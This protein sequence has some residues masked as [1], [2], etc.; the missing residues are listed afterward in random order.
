MKRRNGGTGRRALADDARDAALD[1]AAAALAAIQLAKQVRADSL[2]HRGTVGASGLPPANLRL[3]M[4]DIIYGAVQLQVDFARRLF[5]FN[6]S[7]SAVLRD[8]LRDHLAEVPEAQTIDGTFEEGQPIDLHFVVKNG[9]SLSKTFEFQALGGYKK[10]IKFDPPGVTL[11]GRHQESDNRKYIR[12]T[13]D[14][15][16]VGTY[17]GHISV[18]SQGIRLELRRF[19]ITITGKK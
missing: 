12:A 5:E 15:M 16:K 19:N 18:E 7:T 2:P 10:T 6:K 17:V 14:P 8:K 9:T 13:L 11:P 4:G 3:P 1:S